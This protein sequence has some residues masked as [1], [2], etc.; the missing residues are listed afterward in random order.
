MVL[1]PRGYAICCTARSG[2][3]LLCEALDS[4]GVL[5]HPREYFNSDAFAADPT[6]PHDPEGRL[7]DLVRRAVTPNDVYG[8]KMLAYQAHYSAPRDWAKRLPNLAFVYLYRRDL[9]RQSISDVRAMQTNAYHHGQAE[10]RQPVYDG[11][12]IRQKMLSLA[13]YDTRWRVFFAR[14][15]VEPLEVSYE[16]FL[17][18]SQGVVNAI[19]RLV[20]VPEAK[21][22]PSAIGSRM[23]RDALTEAWRERFL[24]EHRDLA[25][26]D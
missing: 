11:E 1:V 4:T 20:G 2:S 22:E 14:N 13:H 23:Q 25:T 15:G 19:G 18:A 8:L 10:Q 7:D 5:G 12:A 3:S 16:T 24:S 26:F 9:L 17:A 6:Y 21:L